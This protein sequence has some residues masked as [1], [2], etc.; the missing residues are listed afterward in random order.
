MHTVM[1]A[2]TVVVDPFDGPEIAIVAAAIVAA[3]SSI[4]AAIIANR[5]RQHT[6]VVRD[7]V[8]NEHQDAPNPNLREDLDAKDT[9]V[10]RKLDEVLSA[11]RSMREDIHILRQGWRTNR[12]DID[13]LLDTDRRRRDAQAWGPRVGPMPTTR[14]E[15]REMRT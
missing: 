3:A 15:L 5:T 13:D 2:A 14:R 7:Q 8:E 1:A 6:R 11:Q 10:N 12:E 4:T 9:V